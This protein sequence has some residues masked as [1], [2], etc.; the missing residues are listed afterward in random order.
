M[1]ESTTRKSS[2]ITYVCDLE[3][4]YDALYAILSKY[5]IIEQFPQVLVAP[6]GYVGLPGKCTVQNEMNGPMQHWDGVSIPGFQLFDKDGALQ[7][8]ANFT[9]KLPELRPIPNRFVFNFFAHVFETHFMRDTCLWAGTNEYCTIWNYYHRFV[10][11]TNLR[12]SRE[13]EEFLAKAAISSQ[14]RALEEIQNEVRKNFLQQTPMT[15][16]E[17]D[18]RIQRLSEAYY[19]EAI[20]SVLND[21]QTS[22]RMMELYDDLILWARKHIPNYFQLHKVIEDNP[23]G[24]FD[25][26]VQARPGRSNNLVVF[27]H[28]DFRILQWE[29]EH[30]SKYSK[31]HE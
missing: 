18:L 14:H 16:A 13:Q 1:L 3:P 4:F 8:S 24:V 10:D 9:N 25:Y 19:Q 17:H 2:G 6:N 31:K 27:Y 22:E 30:L 5:L 7:W 20:V 21:T 11:K 23:W 15:V 26:T 28:G 29:S 12:I